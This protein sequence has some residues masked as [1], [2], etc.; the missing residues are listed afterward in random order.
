MIEQPS[1]STHTIEELIEINNRIRRENQMKKQL[2][3]IIT[4]DQKKQ[5]EK[6]AAIEDRSV[7]SL[8]RKIIAEYLD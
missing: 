2:S 5:L 6:I 7:A 8:I 1:L 3:V 4:E